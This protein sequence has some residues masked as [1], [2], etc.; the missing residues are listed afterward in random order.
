MKLADQEK[1][2]QAELKGREER[3]QN[4]LTGR[5]ME[6]QQDLADLRAQCEAKEEAWRETGRPLEETLQ[7]NDG[8]WKKELS[9][10]QE[11][12]EEKDQ[13]IGTVEQERATQN[14]ARMETL[15]LLSSAG[16]QQEE[17]CALS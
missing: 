16:R 14:V 4:E 8:S 3:F 5:I 15:A 17:E 10:L 6:A 9:Q 12:V 7:K 2:H 1:R 11:L 13:H